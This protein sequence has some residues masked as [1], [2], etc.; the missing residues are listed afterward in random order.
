MG[1]FCPLSLLNLRGLQLCRL[2]AVNSNPNLNL[3]NSKDNKGPGLCLNLNLNKVSK[4]QDLN[5]NLNLNKVSKAS[6]V[7]NRPNLLNSKVN[8][9][10]RVVSNPD[11]PLN[12]KVNKVSRVQDLNRVLKRVDSR[13]DH[14]VSRDCISKDK[15][16]D[17]LQARG[18]PQVLNQASP[19]NR[20]QLHP[21]RERLHN[22]HRQRSARR[23]QQRRS[24]LLRKER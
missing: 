14:K 2:M 18:N 10:S 17:H 13:Q 12:S 4:A 24:L 7:V 21:N 1:N 3:S 19:S 5:L 20:S 6:K 11:L 23:V 16:R 22:A 15:D 9:V 8:K